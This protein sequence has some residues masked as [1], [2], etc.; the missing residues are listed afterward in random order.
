M[1]QA[2]GK[3]G[4]KGQAASAAQHPAGD[5]LDHLA[6]NAVEAT[7]LSGVFVLTPVGLPYIRKSRHI[8]F[9]RMPLNIIGLNY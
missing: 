3:T 6:L 2:L 8:F 9:C 4:T 7:T 5:L 1:Q